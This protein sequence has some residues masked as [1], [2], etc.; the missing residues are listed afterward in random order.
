MSDPNIYEF[1]DYRPY[2]RAWFAERRGRPSQATFARR[3][4]CAPALVTDILKGKRNLVRERIP[5]FA[6]ELK[7]QDLAARYFEAMV[8]QADGESAAICTEAERRR[9]A[10]QIVALTDPNVG[11]AVELYE[12]WV[13][14]AVFELAKRSDFQADGA[15]VVEQLHRPVGLERAQAAVTWLNDF[16]LLGEDAEGRLSVVL[17]QVWTKHDI[18]HHSE[19]IRAST[20]QHLAFLDLAQEAIETVHGRQRQYGGL[21]TLISDARY[22][23]VKDLVKRFQ[24]E[25]QLLISEPEENGA[26]PR[27]VV[28][29]AFQAFPL[30]KVAP[31]H[32]GT[33]P[34]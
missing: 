34:P 6:R 33:G 14:T 8:L 32:N 4:H 24:S 11:L 26:D 16:G 7:I 23:R 10:I 9:K 3:A 18:E 17:E 5:T 29:V 19:L 27:A 25:L 21:T 12:D 2:M 1:D 31:P 30:T 28:H 22:L 13:R 20:K 15:W